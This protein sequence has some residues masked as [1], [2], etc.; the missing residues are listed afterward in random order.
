[1][2]DKSEMTA[3]QTELW[4][5]VTQV[6]VERKV[7]VD[8]INVVLEDLLG[9]AAVAGIIYGIP[10]EDRA[11]GKSNVVEAIQA[12]RDG[13]FGYASF[14][15]ECAAGVE[16]LVGNQD[17]ARRCYAAAARLGLRAVYTHRP[18]SQ[19]GDL[20]T[21]LET[22][23]RNLRVV[24]HMTDAFELFYAGIERFKSSAT[25]RPAELP[26]TLAQPGQERNTTRLILPVG[27]GMDTRLDMGQ[28]VKYQRESR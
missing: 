15:Y 17:C 1:M 11:L 24:S 4:Q 16:L 13:N 5:A 27:L 23:R 6:A 21:E 9:L 10:E 8:V 3:A 7:S 26:A 25:R 18:T 2:P 20:S 19:T 28:F 22:V 12:E 14:L